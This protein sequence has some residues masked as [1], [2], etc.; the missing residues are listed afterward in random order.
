MSDPVLRI[1]K[2]TVALPAWSDRKHTLPE[3][4]LSVGKKEIVC[5][6]GESGSGKSIMG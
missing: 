6:V 1:E 4:S 2:L 3:V 5:V